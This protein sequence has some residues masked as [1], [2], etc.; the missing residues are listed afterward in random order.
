M[1]FLF[2]LFLSLAGAFAIDTADKDT[3]ITGGDDAGE[4]EF[5]FTVGILISG[6]EEHTFCA[7][8]LVTPRFVLTTANCVIR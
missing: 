3:R 6:D 4:N 2:L 1:R 8:V 5:P 7:G